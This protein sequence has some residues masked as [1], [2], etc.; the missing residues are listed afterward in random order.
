M[1]KK[2]GI[3]SLFLSVLFAACSSDESV[4][5]EGGETNG[6][7]LG[8]IAVNIVQ[9]KSTGT[10]AGEGSTT[11]VTGGF[12]D[13]I[14]KENKAREAT[15]FIFSNSTSEGT[16]YKSVQTITLDNG[17]R[18]GATDPEREC[19][20]NAVLVL[21]GLTEAKKFAGKIYCVLNAP[22][23]IKSLSETGLT[24]EG[25]KKK[26]DSYGASADGTFIMTNSAYKNGDTEVCGTEFTAD[27]FKKSASE[28]I[29]DPIDIYV[30]R[31]V[32]K[33]I[34]TKS[35]PFNNEGALSDEEKTDSLHNLSIK[36]TGIEI[37]N[38]AEKSYLFK[39]LGG[40]WPN[41]SGVHDVSNC[42]SYW[43]TVPSTAETVEAD[44]L[45][46]LNKKYVNIVGNA[47]TDANGV[48]PEQSDLAISDFYIQPNTNQEQP[49]AILVTA[50]L[51]KE[52][53]NVEK[54]VNLVWI[55]GG[56]FL[57]Y[58]AK[59]LVCTYLNSKNYAIKTI[60]GE[61]ETQVTEYRTINP[62]DIDWSQKNGETPITALEDYQA[63]AQVNSDLTVVKY[64]FT[65]KEEI[66][67]E[68]N[69]AITPVNDFLATEKSYYA[70][71]F[72]NGLCYYYKYIEQ[73]PVL[74]SGW[75]SQTEKKNGVVR[76]H[77][78]YLSLD[79][80]KGIGTAVFDPEKVIIPE[81]PKHD[82]LFY[83]AARI[84]VLKWKVV[85]QG[86]TF[87]E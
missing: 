30:E 84:N 1:N 86:I 66:T 35:E 56:Y 7:E 13:G 71:V 22:S 21:D 54:P 14:E 25:L 8:Y 69:K 34:A 4:I 58:S 50:Q 19:V 36:I 81:T 79:G 80:I 41:W 76:N 43:E 47:T 70:E 48:Y 38:I 49:T 32:A 67:L 26:I 65:A 78:Y 52:E 16:P 28:A 75:E 33:V 5:N 10:R 6:K 44:R 11:P 45:T 82:D 68:E 73:T 17:D 3:L 29:A 87:G 51:T 27:N 23:T 20:Y 55:K 24:E 59:K 83:L 61:G 15:F 53:D 60:T 18:T 46:F 85:K 40:T 62:G 37:A 42:R 39:N 77:V 74:G 2:N 63:C 31:I 57:D 12:Q 72:K 64:D 9:S